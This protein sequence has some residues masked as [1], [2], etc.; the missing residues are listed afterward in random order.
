M[1]TH[2]V[3]GALLEWQEVLWL[4][5]LVLA[6]KHHLSMLA[7]RQMGRISP[8]FLLLR[9]LLIVAHYALQ[10]AAGAWLTRGGS[11]RTRWRRC[12]LWLLGWH[13]AGLVEPMFLLNHIQT[14]SQPTCTQDDKIS[15]LCHTVSYTLRMPSWAPLD[16]WFMP[17]AWHVEHHMAPKIPDENLRYVAADV[18]ELAA[19]HGLPYHVQPFEAAM[20][21]FTR[22]LAGVQRVRSYGGYCVL[23]GFTLA[24][25]ALLHYSVSA[26]EPRAE[27]QRAKIAAREAKKN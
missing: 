23:L 4:P 8:D 6:G 5:L 17:L 18:A 25:S 1:E 12:L 16:E 22:A 15:Q 14:G 3:S 10:L 26:V 9:K 13:V 27:A 21:H 11:R 19:R 20:W 2:P 7:W 24:V